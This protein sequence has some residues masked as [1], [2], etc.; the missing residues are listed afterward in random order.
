M[1]KK[2]PD[3]VITRGPWTITVCVAYC[4]CSSDGRERYSSENYTLTYD[5]C[6]RPEQLTPHANEI[7]DLRRVLNALHELEAP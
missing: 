4:G 3:R 2:K 1:S 7:A 6:G 5:N